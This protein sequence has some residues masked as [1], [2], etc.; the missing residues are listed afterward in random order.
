MNKL[1]I[2]ALHPQDIIFRYQRYWQLSIKFATLLLS[3]LIKGNILALLYIV[4]L[5]KRKVMR[6]FPIVMRDS[7]VEFG[8]LGL[9]SLEIELLAQVVNLFVSLCTTDTLTQSLLKVMMECIQLEIGVTTSFLTL[10]HKDF[11]ELVILLQVTLLW[12]GICDFDIQICL[13]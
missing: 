6:I 8:R 3:L 2:S 9:Y 11:K 7:L 4:L 1:E 12:K 5:P 10:Q 13:F